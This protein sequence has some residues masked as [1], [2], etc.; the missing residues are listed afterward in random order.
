VNYNKYLKSKDWQD[1]RKLKNSKKYRCA[2]CG[3]KKD[4]DV[5]HLNYKK[6][7]DVEQTDLR[8]L[9]RRCHFL[10]HR[11]HKEGIIVFKSANHHSRFA[12]IKAKV[13]KELG[14]SNVNMFLEKQ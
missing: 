6:L 7:Y 1:K 9:C 13:K 14:I 5:H 2:I 4:I 10:A 8:K 3:D 12:I 11:L